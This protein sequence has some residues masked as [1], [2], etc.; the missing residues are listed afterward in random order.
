M[1]TSLRNLLLG[2][3]AVLSLA[4][5]KSEDSL[6]S[7][8][9]GP[10]ERPDGCNPVISPDTTKS[11]LCPMREELVGWMESDTFNPAAICADG[12]IYVLFRAE[13]NSARGVGTRTSR[14]GLARSQDGINMSISEEPVFYPGGDGIESL[15]CPGGVEDP[16]IA[17]TEDGLYVMMYTSWNRKVPR[18]CV[19]TSRDLRSWTKHGPAFADAY[20]GRFCDMS[21][22]SASIVTKV[23]KDGLLRI[24]K[25]NGTYLMYWGES[26]VN[27]ATS[28][29]L[30]HWTPMIN[31][32]D[33]SLL[34]VAVPRPGYFDS[35]LTE[36]GPPAVLTKNGIV[37]MY[38]GKNAYGEKADPDYASG[39]YSAG[40]LLFDAKDPTVLKDRLDKPFFHPEADFEKS[41]QYAAGTVFVEGLVHR[42]HEWY[43]YY[44][45][46]DSF[47]GVAI[48]R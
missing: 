3:L 22:K 30:I 23:C 20:G 45:C 36:C 8:A 28:D 19:A 37:V 6:P 14:I 41:G 18:L 38:N 25:V 35:M 44:G 43:L 5:C 10:F 4:G 1:R 29:D 40:Q 17:V 26:M 21:T 11:F 34:A 13:D 15:D 24:T 31:E 2:S 12:D 46:A 27:P 32:A 7:W 33:S 39:T 42:G 48:A 16:R 47:V 9:I